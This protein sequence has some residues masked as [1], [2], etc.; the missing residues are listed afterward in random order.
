MKTRGRPR[1]S[2]KRT[3]SGRLSRA[4][5]ARYDHGTDRAIERRIAYRGNGYDAIGRAYERGLLGRGDDGKP[6]EEAKAM[7]N[8]ARSL[9]RAYWCE[10]EVGRTGCTLGKHGATTLHFGPPIR[11]LDD[12]A[13]ERWL[14]AMLADIH[15]T[16][17][18]VFD[19]LVLDHFPDHGPGWLDRIIDGSPLARDVKF[20]ST[21][22]EV[23]SRMIV[24]R[25]REVA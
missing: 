9:N 10:Y 24:D 20:L 3:T 23:L 7:L 12:P 1:K 8:M 22:V 18:K 25:F 15:W 6:T 17:R 16:E 21:A 2:G 11:G 19:E 4:K 13:Q 5:D 14:N